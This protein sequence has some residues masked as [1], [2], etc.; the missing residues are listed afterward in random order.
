MKLLLIEDHKNI[1]DII[2]DYFEIK[3]YQ[4]D[5]A[6]NGLQGYDLARQQ[7]YDLIIL[8]VMLPKMDGLT[9]CNRLREDGI[10]TPILMLTA[11]DTREDILS[12][13]S[14]GADDYLLKPFDLDILDARIKALTRRHSGGAGKTALHFCEL[15]LDLANRVLHRESQEL[16]LNPTQFII[17]KLLMARAPK[18]VNKEEI[19]TALWGDDEPETDLLRSH[20][21][22]LRRLVDKPFKHAYIKTLPKVGYQLVSEEEQ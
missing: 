16:S 19:S 11:R 3:G 6:H 18:A 1:A 10:N 21:Y 7:H 14:Q 22:Q 8:D 13:F 15:K 12:G 4:L 20:I 5:Y 17:L 9:V 2:F